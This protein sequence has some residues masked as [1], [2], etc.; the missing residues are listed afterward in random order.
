MTT[1][2]FKTTVAAAILLFVCIGAVSGTTIT[3]QGGTIPSTGSSVDFPISVDSL[4]DGLS[5]FVMTVS[6]S[7]SSKAEITT[8]ITPPWAD[9]SDIGGELISGPDK[10]VSVMADSVDVSMA[11]LEENFLPAGNLTLLTLRIEGTVQGQTELRITNLDIQDKD[12]NSIDA[13]VQNGIII[14]GESTTPG[15]PSEPG[16]MEIQS[17]PAGANAYLDGDLVGVTPYIVEDLSP[18]V[19][20]VLIQQDGYEP[21]ENTTVAVS[22]GLTTLVTATLEPVSPSETPPDTSPGMPSGTPPETGSIEIR[23][24]PAGADAYLE[25]DFVGVTPH[26]VEN[27][28]PGVYTVRIQKD[29]YGPY[30]NTSVAVSSGNT[31][32]VSAI[33]PLASSSEGTGSLDISSIPSDA[34]VYLDDIF[35]GPTHLVI[36]DLEPGAYMLSIDKEGYDT[37]YQ[38]ITI[39]AGDTIFISAPLTP[40]P[41]ITQ[42]ATP[43]PTA[44]PSATGGLF[45]VSEPTATVFIDGT[46]RG[47]SNAVINKVPS[48]IRN[49]TLFKAGFAPKSMM[50]TIGV[51]DVT[52]TSKIIL[53]QESVSP[54]PTSLPAT[55]A[56]TPSTTFSTSKTTPASPGSYPQVPTT[57]GVFVYSVP[58][59]CSVFIDE[60]NK[61]L[62][63]GLFTGIEPGNHVVRL[64]LGGYRDVDQSITVQ[65]GVITIVSAMM[66]PDFT[67]LVSAFS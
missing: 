34:D 21:Y 60:T 25:G 55:Q 1:Q 3:A 39:V 26:V 17:T 46:E 2:S 7:D 27:L 10:H 47:Q 64:T 44:L 66:V 20:T 49:V 11:T 52:V 31:T 59:G 12:G 24:T 58:F 19:Y 50:V 13:A 14:I 54:P 40:I 67:V 62:S 16:S 15:I 18:G 43:T 48:G 65:A 4:P 5:G 63:P 41:T 32:V 33:L 8:A 57:G 45:V 56:A 30:E 51:A 35:K 37:W 9:L 28:S 29:E 53:E 23:S 61:G 22:S 6:L 38:A 36:E 42:T